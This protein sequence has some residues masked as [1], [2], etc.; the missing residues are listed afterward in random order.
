MTHFAISTKQQIIQK[1]IANTIN[2][3]TIIASIAKIKVK[4]EKYII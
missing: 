1:I 3:P 4:K 2:N